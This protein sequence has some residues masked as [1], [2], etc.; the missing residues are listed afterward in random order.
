MKT[1]A[2]NGM[3]TPQPG[4]ELVSDLK[5]IGDTMTSEWLQRAGADGEALVEA[6]RAQ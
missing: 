3:K 6:Y 1:L 2:E 4:P 5:A